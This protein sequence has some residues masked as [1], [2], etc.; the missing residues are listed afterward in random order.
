[1]RT[2]A[3]N[4]QT[5]WVKNDWEEMAEGQRKLSPPELYDLQ[6]DPD[7]LHDVA[8]EHPDV[9]AEYHGMLMDYIEKNRAL[10]RGSLEVGDAA[11]KEVP[12]F[13]QSQL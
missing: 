12:L 4:Y 1:M 5:P 11:F 9:A 10:T 7:E 6:A 2:R 3:W 8:A 13:D